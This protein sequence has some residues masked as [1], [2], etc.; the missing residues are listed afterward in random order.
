M[1]LWF[2]EILPLQSNLEISQTEKNKISLAED[3]YLG[4]YVNDEGAFNPGPLLKLFTLAN[5]I[6]I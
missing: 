5:G 1:I 2:Q 4:M 3:H 6:F